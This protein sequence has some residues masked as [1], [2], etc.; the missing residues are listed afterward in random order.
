MFQQQQ[1]NEQ[2]FVERLL[3]S[4]TGTYNDPVS[5]PYYA[6]IDERTLSAVQEVTRGGA[7]VSASTLSGVAGAILRPIAEGQGIVYVA[8]G[9]TTRRFRFL[10]D[11]VISNNFGCTIR[12]YISGYTD[13]ADVSASEHIDPNM[14]LYFNSVVTIRE[15]IEPTLHGNILRPAVSESSHIL[16]GS[17]PSFNNHGPQSM[18]PEDVFTTMSHGAL[19]AGNVMD[20]R[21]GFVG[22]AKKSRRSN[23]SAPVY[24]SRTLKAYRSVMD[25]DEAVGSDMSSMMEDARGKVREASLSQDPFFGIAIDNTGFSENGS[26]TFA[27]LNWLSPNLIDRTAVAMAKGVHEK[28]IHHAGQTEHW[29]GN[30][31]QTQIATI[32]THAV[33]AIMMDLMLTKLSVSMTNMT[34]DGSFDVR[35]LGYRGFSKGLDYTPYLQLMQQRLEVELLRDISMNNTLGL[36][37]R[38]EVD[39]LGDTFVSVGL[40]GQPFIDYVTPS[41]ADALMAP[42]MA[43]SYQPLE[44]LASTVSE[45]AEN[46]PVEPKTGVNYGSGNGAI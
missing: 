5:R 32:M 18:R 36:A 3:L 39:V 24:L 35:I 2:I 22:L 13:H 40:N 10:M 11:V 20:L 21:S 42:V 38:M 44:M 4:E 43:G 34:L 1:P 33:P 7:N 31:H 23:V 9:W 25:D 14:R 45:L 28:S 41:F 16:L 12:Q 26:I 17:T 46:L 15:T 27:E 30:T 37:I 8:N 29:N 19:P 6:G